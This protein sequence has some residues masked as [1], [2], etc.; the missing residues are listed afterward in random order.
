MKTKAIRKELNRMIEERD[1][2]IKERDRRIKELDR[3]I[4][5]L[6]NMNRRAIEAILDHCEKGLRAH[7]SYTGEK[8]AKIEAARRKLSDAHRMLDEGD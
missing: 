1:R 2:R 6:L 8:K 4:I 5:E 3:R 7:G